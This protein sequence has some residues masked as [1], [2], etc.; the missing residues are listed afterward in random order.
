MLQPARI[1]WNKDQAD[2][3]AFTPTS[4]ALSSLVVQDH[5]GRLQG[6]TPAALKGLSGK[7]TVEILPIDYAQNEL[8]FSA[9]QFV[10]LGNIA[11][12]DPF[13]VHGDRGFLGT[14][15]ADQ[16]TQLGARGV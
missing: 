10:E 15:A 14:M 7:Q 12:N 4:L 13:K 6:L 11:V 9:E 16:F 3:F 5:V 2:R 1:I 8:D